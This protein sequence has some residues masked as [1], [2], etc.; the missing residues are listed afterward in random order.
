MQ[1]DPKS[2]KQ[3]RESKGLSRAA[4]AKLSHVSAKQIQ[5]LEQPQEASLEPRKSTVDRL[6]R[7]L[8]TEPDVLAGK[9]VPDPYFSLLPPTIRVSHRLGFGARLAYDLVEGRY[10]V[11]ADA[12]VN[13]APLFFVLLAE[14]S[15]A[16]RGKELDALKEKVDEVT[17]AAGRSNRH[18][19]GFHANHCEDGLRCEKEAIEQKVLL[20]DP[21]EF[22]Y[23]FPPDEDKTT[24]PF[25]E[26]LQELLG[27]PQL[28]GELDVTGI[29]VGK[30][31]VWPGDLMPSYSVCKDELVK[32]ASA[33][34]RAL[35]VLQAGDVR[36]ADIPERLR[37][38]IAAGDRQEWLES[39]ASRTTLQW[40]EELGKWRKEL[41]G[42][43][44]ERK[45]S[46][47]PSIDEKA[48]V[49]HA[50]ETELKTPEMNR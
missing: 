29:E 40:L 11:K 27:Q 39:E 13:M 35:H 28:F 18:R 15:L 3:L 33:N 48:T 31:F 8:D 14:G 17:K 46:E 47:T 43:K 42:E 12:I 49:N 10:G 24:N 7:A 45:A 26:Y 25:A 21:Y 50:A 41:L 1:I 9:K 34:T 32:T 30:G 38:K 37:G 19:A 23:D 16:W 44:A 22:G 5:R 6:V 20:R 2:L 36:I 4:L